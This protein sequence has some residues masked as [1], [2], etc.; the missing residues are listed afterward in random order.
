V[1]TPDEAKMRI[2]IRDLRESAAELLDRVEKGETLI[3]TRRGR[4]VAELRP[5]PQ[6]PITAA[7]LVGRWRTLPA[8]NP[9]RLRDDIDGVIDPTL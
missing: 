4:P 2:T 7:A 6:R 1:S 8:I 9:R 3:V 5:L